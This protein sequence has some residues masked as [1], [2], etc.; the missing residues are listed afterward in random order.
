M[1]P[2]IKKLILN[3]GCSLALSASLSLSLSVKDT[4]PAL[5]SKIQIPCSVKGTTTF[6]PLWLCLERQ[7][8]ERRVVHQEEEADRTCIAN[9]PTYAARIPSHAFAVVK[10]DSPFSSPL[11]VTST[12]A[13]KCVPHIRGSSQPFPFLLLVKE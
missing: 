3:Q 10:P 5:E 4:H 11:Q 6:L 1:T 13:T 9:R 8:R 7:L 12:L 2:I